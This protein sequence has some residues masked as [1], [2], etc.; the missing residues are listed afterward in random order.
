MAG[1]FFRPWNRDDPPISGISNTTGQDREKSAVNRYFEVFAAAVALILVSVA[2]SAADRTDLHHDDIERV[3][4]SN[5]AIA[6][7]GVADMV[8]TRHEQALGLDADSRLFLLDRKID[9]GVRNHRYRQTFRGLPI[10]GEHVVV[11][12]DASGNIST[13]FGRKVAGLASEIPAGKPRLGSS[14]ALV[15]AKGAGLGNRVGFM[16]TSA[17]TW[18]LM[19]HID[20]NGRARKAYVVS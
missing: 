6:V 5:A 7:S 3:R 9:L 10:F 17:E 14:N 15:I 1:T 8:H 19:I 12:E 18:E 11:N 4:Q 20:D 16:R 2:A 13:L